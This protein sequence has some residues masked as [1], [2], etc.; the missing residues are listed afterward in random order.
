MTTSTANPHY[1]AIRKINEPNQRPP[2]DLFVNSLMPK[3]IATDSTS[4]SPKPK[5]FQRDSNIGWGRG[6]RLAKLTSYGYTWVNLPSLISAFL[7]YHPSMPYI[8]K[9]N[10]YEILSPVTRQCL[11]WPASALVFKELHRPAHYVASPKRN[12]PHRCRRWL[13]K[14]MDRHHHGRPEAASM[15]LMPRGKPSA[16]LMAFPV[17]RSNGCL[18][19]H[20][21]FP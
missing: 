2:S 21:I 10:T 7:P 5:A 20:E 18:G 3:S 11:V 16:L 1:L 8:N 19:L 15:S 14:A 13:P 4:L 9:I 6:P 17:F 12:G